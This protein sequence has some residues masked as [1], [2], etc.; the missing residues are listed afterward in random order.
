MGTVRSIDANEDLEEPDLGGGER[1]GAGQ[2]RRPA[3]DQ[4][5]LELA[6]VEG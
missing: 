5:D 3:L 1:L 2:G 6:A 4:V